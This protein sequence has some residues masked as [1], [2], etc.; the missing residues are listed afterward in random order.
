MVRYKPVPAPRG[1]DV[2]QAI[3][4]AVPADPSSTDDCCAHLA[5]SSPVGDRTGAREWLG[6]LEA[7]E[8]VATDGGYYRLAWDGRVTTLADSF[9]RRVFGARE[10]LGAVDRIEPATQEQLADAVAGSDSF[11][12]RDSTPGAGVDSRVERLLGWSELFGLVTESGGT[13]RLGE[14]GQPD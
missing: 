2:L 14:P 11:R 7:L 8:L 1:L 4:R 6:F 13:Y 10:L 12:T 3:H 5:A 9:E